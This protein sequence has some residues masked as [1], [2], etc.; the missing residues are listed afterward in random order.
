MS[1]NLELKNMSILFVL[2][3]T[4]DIQTTLTWIKMTKIGQKSC[5]WQLSSIKIIKSKCWRVLSILVLQSRERQWKERCG[6]N[7]NRQ[8]IWMVEDH[9]YFPIH[10][11]KTLPSLICFE[12]LMVAIPLEKND[13]FLKYYRFCQW[14]NYN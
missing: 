3:S 6:N 2:K 7:Q 1:F 10:I 12:I 8:Q 14:L 4:M 11:F 5:Q 13:L 9:R